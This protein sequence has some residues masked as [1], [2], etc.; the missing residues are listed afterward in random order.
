VTASVVENNAEAGARDARRALADD[1]ID[2][3]TGW[4]PPERLLTLRGWHRGAYSLIQLIVLTV[5]EAEDPLSM[6]RI[7]EALDVSDASATGIVDRIERRGL[8]ERRHAADDRRVVLVHLTE[9]GAAVFREIKQRRR[10][11]LS[12]LVAE[13]GDDDLVALLTGLRAMREAVRRLHEVDGV[14][15]A[16]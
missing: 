6:R 10:A 8:V 3:L 5:L 14:E 16:P 4:S 1:L 2:E 9:R 15:T 7:A 13:L 11:R 12:L